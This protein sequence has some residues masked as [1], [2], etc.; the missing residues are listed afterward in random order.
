MRK[1]FHPKPEKMKSDSSHGEKKYTDY[2]RHRACPIPGC[3]SVVK[4]LSGHICQ[5]HEDIPIGSPLY[6]K[7]LK[8]A[9]SAKTW[10]PLEQ[11]ECCSREDETQPKHCPLDASENDEEVRNDTE[12][13]ERPSAD[14][15]YVI[16][17]APEEADSLNVEEEISVVASFINWLQSA[18]AG[19]KDKKLSKQHGSQL[20]RIL[21]TIDP[22]QQLQSL[23]NKTLIRDTF[24]RQAE[25]KYTADTMKAYLLSLR[26]F[27]AYVIAEEPA[28]VD[29]DPVLV[30]Q[31]QEKA[32][33][34][35][36]SY[37]KDS[38]R[39]H[40]E[41]MSTDLSNL[42]T[43]EQVKEYERSEAARSAVAD[44]EHL[45]GAH[46]LQ[47]NQS[48]Y[49]N[50]RDYILLQITIA[51]VHR[52]G[53]M[54]NMTME[55]Y[56]K[57]KKVEG[58]MVISVKEH[59]TA[60][61]HGPARVVLSSSLFSYLRL[62]INELR[63][64]VV[65]SSS[66]ESDSNNA[67]VF[68]SWNGG[69][70]ESGQVSTA[71]NAARRKGGMEGHVTSTLF[72]KSAVTNVHKGHK[73]MK[74]DLADLMAHKETT[75]QRFYRLKEKEEACVQA[76]SCLPQIMG[77]SEPKQ[78]I[79][80]K[81]ATFESSDAVI[82]TVAD[83]DGA[84]EVLKERLVWNE[85][86]ITALKEVFSKEIEAKSLTT[87]VVKDKIQDHPTL[88]RLDP[89]KV[90]DKVRSE[91]RFGNNTSNQHS[92]MDDGQPSADLPNESDT[93]A[94]KMSRYFANEESSVSM[95]PPSNSSYLTRDR[96][97]FTDDHRKY[98]LKVCGK[99][100]KSGIIS[101][102]VVKD[103]LSK[104]EEGKEMLREFTMKQLINRLKYERRLNRRK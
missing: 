45:S 42:V 36:M 55:E 76:A 84:D 24:L 96:N 70:L 28:G 38:K 20:L 56:K 80:R 101:Q 39:R 63:R 27:C 25:K 67:H 8:E 4:R 90:Y 75:A 66:E 10:K 95:V 35:S 86:D 9:R 31:I 68:L 102:P 6:K 69:K 98:L 93:L 53:V 50:V 82:S 41:K 72:R 65:E 94:D 64:H 100:V 11:I 37:R 83:K 16:M 87:A 32:R 60:D 34:W 103:L 18:D 92:D 54:A 62:Y 29:V 44:L 104:D 5:V 22:S 12:P 15:E 74:S 17:E 46:S 71:I 81:E 51:N 58:N 26:H 97:I 2:H 14:E 1:S 3:R 89:K 59:K 73:E 33:L 13:S 79:K 77:S 7:I 88:C 40:L 30:R 19:R 78:G 47:V 91:W 99:M 48:V 57:A 21:Q 43:P 49:T 61:T 85:E 52:S 23:F